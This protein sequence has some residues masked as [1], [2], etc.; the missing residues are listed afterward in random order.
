MDGVWGVFRE[1]PGGGGGR[2][3]VVLSPIRHP[4]ESYGCT[5]RRHI[6]IMTYWSTQQIILLMQT[7]SIFLVK[8]LEYHRHAAIGFLGVVLDF[9]SR[10]NQS[11]FSINQCFYLQ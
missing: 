2:R 4:S 8:N 5:H 10:V 1:G 9:G 6:S 11:M 3:G 7:V